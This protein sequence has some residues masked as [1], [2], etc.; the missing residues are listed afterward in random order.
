[1]NMLDKL[2]GGDL[3][4]IGRSNEIVAD[5]EEDSALIAKGE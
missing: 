5:I 4:S 1:M 3:H 2:R